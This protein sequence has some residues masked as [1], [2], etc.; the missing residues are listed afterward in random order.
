MF[1]GASSFNGDLSEWDVS[2]VTNMAHM[3]YSARSFNG[4]LSKW[5]VSAVTSMEHMFYSAKSFNTDLS[6]WDVSK[7]S[8]MWGMFYAAS[9]F[10][11]VLY[12]AWRSSKATKN[13]MFIGSSGR[14]S[15]TSTKIHGHHTSI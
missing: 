15:K 2:R 14:I 4:D 5:D 11:Q 6:K 1:N 7:V 12:G 8:S 9:S 3:F 10:G 13:E